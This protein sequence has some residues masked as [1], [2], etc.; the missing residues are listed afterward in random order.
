MYEYSNGV[1][2]EDGAITVMESIDPTLEVSSQRIEH[3]GLVALYT[4]M[5]MR[6]LSHSVREV[7]KL[8]R[9]TLWLREWTQVQVC[10]TEIAE[11][12]VLERGDSIDWMHLFFLLLFDQI[13][14]MLRRE[15]K[16]TGFLEQNGCQKL[17]YV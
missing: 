15:V 16:K 17:L 4:Y 2:G 5:S 9:K 12:I 8:V 1:V 11:R 10:P 6:M 7:E 13:H 3:S 14:I